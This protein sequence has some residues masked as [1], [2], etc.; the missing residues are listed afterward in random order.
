MAA[1]RRTLAQGLRQIN[2][3]VQAQTAR[4]FSTIISPASPIIPRLSAPLRRAVPHD[5]VQSR[6]FAVSAALSHGH[7]EPPKPGEE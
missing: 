3:A 6:T 2:T 1:T 7:V 4:P 5:R